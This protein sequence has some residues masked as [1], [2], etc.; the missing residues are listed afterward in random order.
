MLSQT[1]RSLQPL[2]SNSI[3]RMNPGNHIS[4]ILNKKGRRVMN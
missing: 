3:E 1:K 4:L 2:I